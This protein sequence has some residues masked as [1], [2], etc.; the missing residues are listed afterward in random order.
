MGAASDIKSGT[1]VILKQSLASPAPLMVSPK[2]PNDAGDQKRSSDGAPIEQGSQTGILSVDPD[3]PA[4][5]KATKSLKPRGQVRP[6]R[7]KDGN[8]HRS[9][10]KKAF[11]LL[12]KAL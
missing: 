11:Q 6:V 2:Y 4:E 12:K 9:L 7:H 8:N 3:H 1:P 10:F 5:E